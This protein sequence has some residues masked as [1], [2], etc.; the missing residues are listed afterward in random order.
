MFLQLKAIV[1]KVKEKEKRIKGINQ[2]FSCRIKD[3]GFK[4]LKRNKGSLD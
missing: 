1:M 4:R 3:A 2:D